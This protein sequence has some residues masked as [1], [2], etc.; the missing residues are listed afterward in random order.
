MV[1]IRVSILFL[2]L[3]S[4][5][6][7]VVLIRVSI[8]FLPL[9]SGHQNFNAFGQACFE[10]PDVHIDLLYMVLVELRSYSQDFL[11]IFKGFSD[12]YY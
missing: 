7:L 10:Q 9:L 12:N 3:L 4:G 11:V 1:L 5:H 2:P 8:L 6:L